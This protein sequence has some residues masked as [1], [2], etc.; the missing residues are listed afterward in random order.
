MSRLTDL[1][2]AEFDPAALRQALDDLSKPRPLFPDDCP[3]V[4]V[5]FKG[6]VRASMTDPYLSDSL[7]GDWTF[8]CTL[9]GRER[10][11]RAVPG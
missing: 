5:G 7:Y 9:C 2:A 3:H 8:I 6:P 10:V 4:E 1:P 11:V